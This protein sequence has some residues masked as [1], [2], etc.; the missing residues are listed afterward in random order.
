MSYI[1]QINAKFFA[2]LNFAFHKDNID[3]GSIKDHKHPI[4][5]KKK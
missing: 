2:E 1:A 4:I 5:L 3:S